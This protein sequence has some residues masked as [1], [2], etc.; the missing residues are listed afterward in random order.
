LWQFRLHPAAQG[1]GGPHMLGVMRLAF[2]M[3][4]EKDEMNE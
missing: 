2:K 3:N 1:A 4:F